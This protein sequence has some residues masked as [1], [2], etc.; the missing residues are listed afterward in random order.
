MSRLRHSSAHG[1]EFSACHTCFP[2]MLRQS[3]LLDTD[4]ENNFIF[5]GC[6]NSAAGND[7][8]PLLGSSGSTGS[9]PPSSLGFTQLA[10]GTL[11][12]PVRQFR[13]CVRCLKALG[14]SSGCQHCAA[15]CQRPNS[16]EV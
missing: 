9:F 3:A 1:R 10:N 16:F 6:P 14:S 2:F 5:E 13:L 8:A 15:Y 4:L 12:A 7:E 11:D